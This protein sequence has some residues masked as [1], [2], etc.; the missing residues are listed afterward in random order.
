MI[1]V[2]CDDEG[3]GTFARYRKDSFWWYRKVI[4]TNGSDL[5]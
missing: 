2:D 1:Y 3:K 4:A 5:Q